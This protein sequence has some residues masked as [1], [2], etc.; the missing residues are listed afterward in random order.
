MFMNLRRPLKEGE[1]FKGTLVFEKAGTLV[2][3]FKVEAMGAS[4]GHGH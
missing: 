2:V 1:K 4:P 3:E